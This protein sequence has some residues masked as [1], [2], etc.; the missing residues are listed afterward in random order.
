MTNCVLAYLFLLLDLASRISRSRLQALLS[1]DRDLDLDEHELDD[2][3]EHDEWL[4]DDFDL[5]W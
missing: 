2:L 5:W 4:E 3:E 1:K